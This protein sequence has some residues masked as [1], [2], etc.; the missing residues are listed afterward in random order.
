MAAFLFDE[1]IRIEA[2]ISHLFEMKF[3]QN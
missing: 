1:T 3:C 2:L